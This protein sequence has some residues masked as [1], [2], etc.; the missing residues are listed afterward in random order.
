M[1][2]NDPSEVSVVPGSAADKAGLKNGD[3]IL[4]AD[5]QK[6]DKDHSLAKIVQ[7]KKP[8]DKIV[9]KILRSKQE[10]T[11]PA[12]LGEKSSQ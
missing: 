1:Q 4:A 12:I 5:G 10:L 8:G 6:I 11:L 3:I 2:G 7:A 9:L